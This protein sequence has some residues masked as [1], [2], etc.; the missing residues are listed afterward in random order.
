MTTALYPN[1]EAAFE[2]VAMEIKLAGMVDEL[3][4]IACM[5]K[6]AMILE[7]FVDYLTPAHEQMLKEAFGWA[8]VKGALGGAGKALAGGA[9]KAMGAVQGAGQQVAGAVKNMGAGGAATRMRAAGAAHETDKAF[10][11]GGQG[12]HGKASDMRPSAPEHWSDAGLNV[13]ASGA[14]RYNPKEVEGWKLQQ[15]AAE[16]NASWPGHANVGSSG[17]QRY[18]PI[19]VSSQRNGLQLGSGGRALNPAAMPVP[20]N[21]H[22]STL[23]TGRMQSIPGMGGGAGGTVTQMPQRRAIPAMGMVG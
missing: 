13:G 4:G 16:L 12:F 10:L 21:L 17:A 22:A 18:N 2:K 11:R 19:A 1:Y 9:Q 23:P 6:E 7:E 15:S 20:A 3:V 8:D 14:H 5:T